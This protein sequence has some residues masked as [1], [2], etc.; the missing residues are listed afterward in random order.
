MT[1][2]TN[3]TDEHSRSLDGTELGGAELEREADELE[4]LHD[5]LARRLDDLGTG[6]D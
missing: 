2:M 5:E 1:N 6:R 3:M 4:H